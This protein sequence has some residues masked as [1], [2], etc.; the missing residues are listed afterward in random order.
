MLGNRSVR[1]LK[2]ETRNS[3]G[4]HSLFVIQ[5]ELSKYQLATGPHLGSTGLYLRVGALQLLNKPF[6]CRTVRDTE[7]AHRWYK[8]GK[9]C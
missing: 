6:G 2:E 7:Q 3:G 5:P 1:V 9:S 4:I 8:I